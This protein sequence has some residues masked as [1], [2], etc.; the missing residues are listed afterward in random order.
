MSYTEKDKAQDCNDVKTKY[1][2]NVD[3]GAMRAF[4]P[5]CRSCDK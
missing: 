3:E 5:I 2:L 4:L 1:I